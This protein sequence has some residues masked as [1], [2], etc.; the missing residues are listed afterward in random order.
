MDLFK[1]YNDLQ[2][3]LANFEINLVDSIVVT[4]NYI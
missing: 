1:K 2:T 3:K 4:E